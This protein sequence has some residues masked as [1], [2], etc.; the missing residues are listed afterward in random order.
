MD[1]LLYF[2]GGDG[3]LLLNLKH[4]TFGERQEFWGSPPEVPTHRV[5]AD[6]FSFGLVVGL[7]LPQ[8]A[9]R[10]LDDVH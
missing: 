7:E 10:V 2:F 8:S 3:I 6:A 1:F 9:V 5:G 4:S